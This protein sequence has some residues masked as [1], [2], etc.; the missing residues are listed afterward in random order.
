MRSLKY[1]KGIPS[2]KLV[3]QSTPKRHS[4]ELK[5]KRGSGIQDEIFRSAI[6][7]ARNIRLCHH[8]QCHVRKDISSKG[9]ITRMA[10]GVHLAFK[11]LGHYAI[12]QNHFDYSTI[13]G[14]VN[15]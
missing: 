4:R 11:V 14:T 13:G 2:S 6:T 8:M 3:L 1:G 9:K 7:V 5:A 15:V 12:Y 10:F